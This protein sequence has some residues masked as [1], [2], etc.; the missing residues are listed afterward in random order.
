MYWGSR[1]SSPKIEQANM[2]GSDRKVLV[3]SGLFWVNSLAL[4]YQNGLLYWCDA[5]FKRIERIDLQGN[6]RKMILDLFLDNRHP[7]GLSLSGYILYWSDWNTK[8]I[9]QYD[10]KSL[11]HKDVVRGMGR[12]MELHIYDHT[13]TFDGMHVS[14]KYFLL[15]RLRNCFRLVIHNCS[16]FLLQIVNHCPQLMAPVNG[17]MQPCSNLT[18]QTCHFS[19]DSGYNLTGSTIRRCRSNGTWTGSQTQCNGKHR[20]LPLTRCKCGNECEK[21]EKLK[22]HK[23]PF[24]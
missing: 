16:S 13:H 10:M 4:D 22:S 19:C 11:V 24:I 12:P 17:N 9:H 6:T 21:N 15:T 7:F 8:S 18:G 2:D 1:G 14:R 5:L 23:L 20:A 3:S